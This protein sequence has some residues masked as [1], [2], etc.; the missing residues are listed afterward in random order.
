MTLA[1]AAIPVATAD[2]TTGASLLIL[3]QAAV[4]RMGVD[5]T[6]LRGSLVVDKTGLKG[7]FDIQLQFTP[8][9]LSAGP[10]PS[11][12]CGPSLFTAIQEQLGLKLESAKAPVEV[13]VID[14]AEK[15][16]EN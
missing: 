6:A 16:S 12:G 11:D 5:K 7:L 10:P 2:S 13:L 14:N 9:A 4:G 15:P 1:G 8:D 3:L